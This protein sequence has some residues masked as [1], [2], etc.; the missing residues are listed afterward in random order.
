MFYIEKND[1]PNFIERKLGILKIMDNTIK[2][3]IA[4]ELKEKQIEKLAIR[5]NK[6]I[7]RYS[8]SKKVVISKELKEKQIYINYLNTYGIEISDG[9]WL[10]EYLLPDITQYIINKKQLEK[11]RNINTNKWFNRNRNRKYKNIS[12]K[13]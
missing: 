8:N 10:F 3:P 13:V 4:E 1:K 11:V 6:M 7:E 2:L 9:K 5:T 12:K